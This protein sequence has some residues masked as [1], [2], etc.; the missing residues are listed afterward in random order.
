ME[1][2]NG[3]DQRGLG[4]NA[5]GASILVLLVALTSLTSATSSCPSASSFPVTCYCSDSSRTERITTQAKFLEARE[6][7]TSCCY[8]RTSDPTVV[9]PE[10]ISFTYEPIA[11]NQNTLTTVE[12]A[13]PLPPIVS[14]IPI[15]PKKRIIASSTVTPTSPETQVRTII[16]TSTSKFKAS[17]STVTPTFTVTAIKP[18]YSHYPPEIIQLL[19][20]KGFDI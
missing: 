8:S 10:H 18:D 1:L 9:R 20:Q 7:P 6:D 13:S 5:L 17:S 15:S 3:K 12:E 19:K 11:N 16:A 2:T 4:R 14:D